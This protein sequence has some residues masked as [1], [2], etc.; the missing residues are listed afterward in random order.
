MADSGSG[1]RILNARDTMDP[2]ISPALQR[3][4]RCHLDLRP[5]GVRPPEIKLA[6]G[7]D[8]Q[9]VLGPARMRW[10]G[11]SSQQV[12]EV[13]RLDATVGFQLLDFCA[14]ELNF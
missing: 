11:P 7:H 4:I 9:L 10:I 8:P 3:D 12:Q 2:T 13:W 1:E 6:L 14:Q 5:E